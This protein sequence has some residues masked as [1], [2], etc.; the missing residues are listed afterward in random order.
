M[1]YRWGAWAFEVPSGRDETVVSLLDP[2]DPPRWNLT[3]RSEA[4]PTSLEAWALAQRT[5]PGVEVVNRDRRTVAGYP[6]VTVEHRLILEDRTPLTQWQAGIGLSGQVAIV[7][8]TT[9]PSALPEAKVAFE[10]VLS[11]WKV[12]G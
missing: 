7:T 10:R 2:Q 8:M 1:T 4:L 9:R 11:S 3:I 5:P 12:G 6:A